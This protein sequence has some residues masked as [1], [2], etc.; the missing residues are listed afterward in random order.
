MLFVGAVH[1]HDQQRQFGIGVTDGVIPKL[2]ALVFAV[3]DDDQVGIAEFLFGSFEADFVLR[4]I[5][6]GFSPASR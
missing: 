3:F 1:E 6:F 2:A 5:S 4:E